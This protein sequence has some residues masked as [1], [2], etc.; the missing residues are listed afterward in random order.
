MS[1]GVIDEGKIN[2]QKKGQLKRWRGFTRKPSVFFLLQENKLRPDGAQMS[3]ESREEA[4]VGRDGRRKKNPTPI[5]VS[6]CTI[7][8]CVGHD[9]R[10]RERYIYI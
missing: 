10:I 9:T 5:V 6:R 8:S 1:P 2:T 7:V 3:L 4:A